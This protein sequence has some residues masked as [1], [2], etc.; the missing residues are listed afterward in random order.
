[1][2]LRKFGTGSEKNLHRVRRSGWMSAFLMTLFIAVLVT[3]TPLY[4]PGVRSAVMQA[5][6]GVC[7]QLPHRSPHVAGI[8]L[9]VCHRCLGI[10][11]ALPLA[12]LLYALTRG[13][14]PIRGKGGILILMLAALPAAVDW[15]GDVLGWWVNTPASRM[16]TGAIFGLTAGYFFTRAVTDIVSERA[17]KKTSK[18]L[19]GASKP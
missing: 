18:R 2:R 9:A 17:R 5:F 14:W 16:T 12:A 19:D 7:H 15:L 11:W 6:A 10:Y 8:Q 3:L 1:M 4:P 13:F